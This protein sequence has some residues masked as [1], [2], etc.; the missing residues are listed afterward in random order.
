MSYSR[1]NAKPQPFVVIL[2]LL[3]G[4]GAIGFIGIVG[5]A[6]GMGIWLAVEL[7]VLDAAVSVPQETTVY[8]EL[9]MVVIATNNTDSDITLDSIDISDSFLDGFRVIDVQP[10]SKDTMGLWG[11]QSWEF[12]RSVPPGQSVKVRFTLQAIQEGRFTGDVDICNPNQDFN[13]VIADVTV[14]AN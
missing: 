5:L 8:S 7:P 14:R 12:G 6:L 13:T 11:M 3:G 2:L 9:T 10:Q 4:I 1:G